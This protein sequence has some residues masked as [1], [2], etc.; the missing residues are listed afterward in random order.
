MSIGTD[1][2]TSYI[3]DFLD[4]LIN[5]T[6]IIKHFRFLSLVLFS[7][8]QKIMD[9]IDGK[10]NAPVQPVKYL[11][12][13]LTILTSFPLTDAFTDEPLFEN[14]TFSAWYTWLF[15][16]TFALFYYSITY[17]IFRD[18]SDTHRGLQEFL[19]QV[20]IFA[21]TS[22]IVSG[23]ITWIGVVTQDQGFESLLSLSFLV[24]YTIIFLR[25]YKQ[26][27][28]MSY[29][30]IILYSIVVIMLFLISFFLI[31]FLLA[32]LTV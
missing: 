21:G 9:I 27:W 29:S 3:K 8:S 24:W 15:I 10:E 11:S 22:W 31:G 6:E 7:S 17:K 23:I 4:G 5:I 18:V 30:N 32:L 1:A 20:A 28:G 26:F 14:S 2:N 13:G 12:F 19:R 25:V 16:I